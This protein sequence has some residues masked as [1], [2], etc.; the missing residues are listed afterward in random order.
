MENRKTDRNGDKFHENYQGKHL[1]ARSF[2]AGVLSFVAGVCRRENKIFTKKQNYEKQVYKDDFGL[3]SC[4]SLF[5]VRSMVLWA[6]SG[7]GR[8]GSIDSFFGEFR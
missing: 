8:C 7:L 4:E 6:E 2:P 3:F 1:L 5:F